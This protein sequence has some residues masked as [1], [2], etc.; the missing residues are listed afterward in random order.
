[1]FA[2]ELRLRSTFSKFHSLIALTINNRPPSVL[3]LYQGQLKLRLQKRVDL[4]H[5]CLS[6][7]LISK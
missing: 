7:F 3:L 1:M 2:L 6:E 4:L 5:V